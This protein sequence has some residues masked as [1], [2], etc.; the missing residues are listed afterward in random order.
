MT[1]AAA[2]VENQ[3]AAIYSAALHTAVKQLS[4]SFG[5]LTERY[6]NRIYSVLQL[7]TAQM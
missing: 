3:H 2:N 6:D 5:A 1:S 4:L 7:K